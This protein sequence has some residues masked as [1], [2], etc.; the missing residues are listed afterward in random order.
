MKK[1]VIIGPE[2]TGKSTLCAE[3]ATHFN[4][5]WCPEFAREYLLQNGT[6]YNVNDLTIIAKGQLA[7]EDDFTGAVNEHWKSSIAKVTNTPVLFIDTDMLVMKVWSEFVFNT[8]D[9]FIKEQIELRTY[10]L[11]LLCNTDLPWTKDELREYPD[12]EIRQAL[13]LRYKNLLTAQ[14]VPFVEIKG[15]QSKRLEAAIA[16]IHQFLP[17]I[18]A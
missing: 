13:F 6:H 10:D 16:G 14:K 3:L 4:T 17:N 18:V 7:K 8:C 2:S 1:I 15:I 11:Y 5:L 12:V 9:P